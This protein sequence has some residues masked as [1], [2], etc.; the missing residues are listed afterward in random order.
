MD[1]TTFRTGGGESVPAI[2]AIAA[3]TYGCGP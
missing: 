3:S 1:E 2:F